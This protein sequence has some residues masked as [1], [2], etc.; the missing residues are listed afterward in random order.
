MLVK[1]EADIVKSVILDAKKWADRIF[2]MDNGSTDG[3][4][5]ITQSLADDIVVPW[6]QD[7]RPYSN[8]LR[9][10]VFNEFRH[11]A[12]DGDWWCFKLDADEFY[13]VVVFDFLLA[14]ET[15]LNNEELQRKCEFEAVS[16]MYMKRAIF[17]HFRK[18]KAQ[19]R[20]SEAGADI[21]LD[22]MNDNIGQS[23]I[24]ENV[25]MI[26]YRE[27]VKEIMNNLTEEQQIIFSEKLDGYSLKEI[28]DYNGIDPK[29]VYKQ[30]TKVK[31]IVFD[32][33]EIKQK[34]G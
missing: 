4:W 11:E 13:D 32:V 19:K 3:T 34:I 1:N 14:V 2:I 30:F 7:F 25:S 28:A 20:S 15:Y 16:Y 24:K 29:R 18:Q 23:D 12:K 6:K 22:S 8:G 9:A 10:D 17:V 31:S 5:E 21:S 33:M 27:T 26:E